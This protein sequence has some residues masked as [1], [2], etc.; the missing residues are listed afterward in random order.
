MSE[1]VRLTV[2]PEAAHVAPGAQVSLSLTVQNTGG[3]DARYRLAVGGIPETWCVLD[4]WHLTLGPGVHEQVQITVQPP[5]HTATVAGSYSLTVGVISEDDPNIWLSTTVPLTL[6]TADALTMDVAP[7]A[8]EGREARFRITYLNLSHAPVAVALVAH[9]NEHALRFSVK[10]DTPVIV[11]AGGGGPVTVHVV[12]KERKT[13]GEPH[14]Y[15]IEFRGVQLGAEQ[16]TN[17]L[18]VRRARFVYVPRYKARY[19]P[20]WLRRTPRWALL[21]PFVLL[22]LLLVFAGGRTLPT[23]AM[24]TAR[25]PTP[26]PTRVVPV[27]QPVVP[28]TRLRG[29]E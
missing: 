29:R 8:V 10:P 16:A 20:A 15:E 5:R 27:A 12:P 17:P 11:P 21:P 14:P 6:N 24:K 18:L 19:L 26:P 25:T 3:S 4:T 22:L 1:A 13:F 9:D 23:P 7:P 2:V 28:A